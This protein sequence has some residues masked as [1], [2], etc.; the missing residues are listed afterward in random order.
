[1]LKEIIKNDDVREVI[2]M[3]LGDYSIEIDKIEGD[4]ITYHKEDDEP[5]TEN[6]HSFYEYIIYLID[7]SIKVNEAFAEQF[8]SEKN[9]LV[10]YINTLK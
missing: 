3:W 5:I 9:V 7:E 8:T 6:L 1:M 4:K 10:E 2:E